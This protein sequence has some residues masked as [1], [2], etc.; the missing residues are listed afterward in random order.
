MQGGRSAPGLGALRMLVALGLFAMLP[1]CA[2]MV[3]GTSQ[4]VVVD[5]DPAGASCDLK[6]SGETLTTLAATPGKVN[7]SRSKND[8]DV[9][10]RKEGFAQAGTKIVPSFNGAT[11]GNVLVGGLIGVMV[12]AASGANFNYPAHN[13]V[14]L[15]PERFDS[16]AARDAYFAAAAQR[17][18][19][20]ADSDIKRSEPGWKASIEEARDRGLAD[21]ETRRATTV[22]APA[23]TVGSQGGT[24]PGQDKS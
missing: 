7:V 16:E 2:T 12:D 21:L 5:T 22:V 20:K 8:I 1:A 6:R 14:S 24:R 19:D 15:V 18:R 4:D 10:C 17:L 13:Y 3:A 11:I 23:T 9:M